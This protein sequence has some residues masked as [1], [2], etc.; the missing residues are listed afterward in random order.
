MSFISSEMI[1]SSDSFLELN[2]SLE[3]YYSCLEKIISKFSRYKECSI[4]T[5]ESS[6]PYD[7]INLLRSTKYPTSD[8]IAV[9]RALPKIAKDML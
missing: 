4:D 3:E 6:T 7:D 9:R 8:D 2:R 1:S 5:F